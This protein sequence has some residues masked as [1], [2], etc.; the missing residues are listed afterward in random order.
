MQDALADTYTATSGTVQTTTIINDSEFDAA[1]NWMY[2]T[3]ITRYNTQETY[4]PFSLVTREQAAKMLSQF[5]TTY[6]LNPQRID[7]SSCQFGDTANADP[8]LKPFILDACQFSIFKGS[9]GMFAPSRTLTKAELSA[10]LIRMF[11]DGQLNENVTPWWSNYFFKAQELGMTKETNMNN[12][13]NPVSRYELALVLYR[14][15]KI[16]ADEEPVTPL[17]PLTG[18]TTTGTIVTNTGIIITTGSVIVTGSSTVTSGDSVL[19]LIGEGSNASDTIEFQESVRWMYDNGLTKYSGTNS[20]GAFDAL[21]REQAAKMLVQYRSIMFPNKTV[22]TPPNCTFQD[23]KNGDATLSGR[24]VQSCKLNILKGGDG[25]FAPTKSLTR[26]E[27]IAVLLRM[28]DESQDESMI[29]RWTNYFIRANQ[30]GLINE[31]TDVNFSKPITRYEMAIL[32]YRLKVKNDLVNGLNSDLM[33]NKLISMVSESNNLIVNT[34]SQSRGYILMNAYLLSDQNSDYFLVDVFGTTYRLA[35]NTIR[36]YY[37]K[38][39]VWYGDIYSLDGTTK[40]G[41]ANFMVN[42]NVVLQG[43]IRPFNDGKPS[44]FV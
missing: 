24:I 12:F 1:L 41:I 10:A 7:I 9:Q 42:D 18:S 44:Y 23:L 19:N 34:G 2:N 15:K 16:Y 27:A 32:M 4:G 30:L 36:K 38:Q 5:F 8:T 33:Q 26:A 31:A 22:V 29:P 13:Q 25:F 20:F 43:T 14:F 28:F 11:S 17:V 37:D 3:Q 21:T 39:Y 40:V 35:K 6:V